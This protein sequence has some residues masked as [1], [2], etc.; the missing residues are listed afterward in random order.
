MILLSFFETKRKC[1]H[2]DRDRSG[3]GPTVHAFIEDEVEQL[4]ESILVLVQ[5]D[6]GDAG[7]HFFH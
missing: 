2:I 6:A 1:I 7:V 4:D 3:G 5:E